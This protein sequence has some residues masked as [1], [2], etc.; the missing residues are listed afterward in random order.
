MKIAEIISEDIIIKTAQDG[1]G[2]LGNLYYQDFDKVINI[3]Q[4]T[5]SI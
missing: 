1:L 5:F 2:V 4:Q 3:L